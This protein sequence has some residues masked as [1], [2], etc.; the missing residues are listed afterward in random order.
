MADPAATHAAFQG[1]SARSFA[2]QLL[3]V[4]LMS[5]HR[6]PLSNRTASLAEGIEATAWLL[7]GMAT[8]EER[9]DACAK[10][11]T[12]RIVRSLAAVLM[13]DGQ[14]H[15]DP[16]VLAKLR[17]GDVDERVVVIF[18]PGAGSWC[19]ADLRPH[20][21]ALA[22]LQTAAQGLPLPID[23]ADLDGLLTT[24]CGATARD[25]PATLARWRRDGELPRRL[26]AIEADA[27]KLLGVR[28]QLTWPR[29]AKP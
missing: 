22:A 20:V 16:E 13:D 25:L 8:R 23:D 6:A 3:E 14:A 27:R 18:H 12:R 10:G 1:G 17:V 24:W 9:L 26:D 7:D 15:V 2:D 19:D 5:V 21:R 29:L 11:D 28:P 4:T